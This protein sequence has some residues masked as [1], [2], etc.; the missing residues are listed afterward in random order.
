MSA[1]AIHESKVEYCIN[2]I[3]HFSYV[4]NTNDS[5]Q[6]SPNNRYLDVWNKSDAVQ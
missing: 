1:L 6:L 3:D 4:Y 2:L 5:L